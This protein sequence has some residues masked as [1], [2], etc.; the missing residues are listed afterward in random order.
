M[1]AITFPA[2]QVPTSERELRAMAANRQLSIATLRGIA[3]YIRRRVDEERW[4]AALEE[5]ALYR[6]A[7]KLL[8]DPAYGYGAAPTSPDT[9]AEQ[10]QNALG[11][12]MIGD[13][14]DADEEMGTLAGMITDWV[15]H[16][17]AED[18]ADA[19]VESDIDSRLIAEAMRDA[20]NAIRT[21]QTIDALVERAR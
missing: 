9:C 2:V 18:R 7:T 12:L 16:G 19:R 11:Y 8:E 5:I 6:L 10:A 20:D 4:Q 17:E 15:D 13:T 21:C 3:E 14:A 1:T